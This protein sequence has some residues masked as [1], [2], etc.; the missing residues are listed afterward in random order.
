[1]QPML[2]QTDLALRTARPADLGT[3]HDIRRAAILGVQV[4][5][6]PR[7]R[8][9]WANRRGPNSFAARVAAGDVIIASL[10]GTDIGWGSSEA[11]HISALYVYPAYGRRGVG[12]KLLEKLEATVAQRG[13]EFVHLESS[14][15]AV[16]FYERLGYAQ[17]GSLRVDG[18]LPMRKRLAV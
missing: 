7:A 6:A 12:R 11:D 16:S 9:A 17:S 1:M 3:M 2:A 15:N 5:L 4:D 18:S 14:L 8:E 10:A 13:H